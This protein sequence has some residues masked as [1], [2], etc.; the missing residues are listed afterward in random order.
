[1]VSPNVSE[2]IKMAVVKTGIAATQ[3]GK[4][5]PLDIQ[6][7]EKINTNALNKAIIFRLT[8]LRMAWPETRFGSINERTPPI[9]NSQAL[10]GNKKKDALGDTIGKIKFRTNETMMIPKRV[11]SC[12]VRL[13]GVMRT[14][15]KGQTR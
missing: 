1:M 10:V 11:V 15:K 13:R 2:Y 6:I 7:K 14:I 8:V 4:R 5:I 9:P 3:P 12:A